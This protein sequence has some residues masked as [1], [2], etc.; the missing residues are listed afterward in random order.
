M[1]AVLEFDNVVRAYAQGA[2]VLNGVSFTLHEGEVAGLLAL[3]HAS[4]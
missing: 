4:P 1:T 3:S 2:P